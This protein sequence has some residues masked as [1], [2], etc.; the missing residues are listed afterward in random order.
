M[1]TSTR[2]RS[3]PIPRQVPPILSRPKGCVF[4]PRC[5]YVEP[6]RCT[7]KP[8]ATGP[9]RRERLAP[10][11]MRPGARAPGHAR[12]MAANGNQPHNADAEV[13]P[14]L[15]SAAWR[16][17]TNNRLA[18]SVAVATRSHAVDGIDL[19]AGRA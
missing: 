15:S 6:G 2:A 4:A 17:P 18:S 1:P 11:E 8:I 12:P 14:L 19:V 13:E 9:L 5:I 10:R 3:R 16:S 7:T